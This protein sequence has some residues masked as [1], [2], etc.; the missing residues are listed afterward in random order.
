MLSSASTPNP[1]VCIFPQHLFTHKSVNKQ[2]LATFYVL[3]TREKHKEMATLQPRYHQQI[4]SFHGNLINKPI[5]YQRCWNFTNQHYALSLLLL[6]Y[7]SCFP[8]E[9]KKKKYS[10]TF[11]LKGYFIL[12]GL[13]SVEVLKSVKTN[14]ALC[15]QVQ[16]QIIVLPYSSVFGD[17]F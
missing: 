9:E 5:S 4:S 7:Q 8:G 6:C 17:A 15:W 16:V 13:G 10:P 1:S 14:I 3:E 12:N 2:S 11:L